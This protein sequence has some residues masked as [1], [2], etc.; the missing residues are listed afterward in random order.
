MVK[1]VCRCVPG[2]PPAREVEFGIIVLLG[3]MTISRAQYQMAPLE[4]WEIKT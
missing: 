1:E 3:T 2:F 4:L